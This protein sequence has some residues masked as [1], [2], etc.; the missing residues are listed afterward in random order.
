VESRR[1]WL[2][3]ASDTR[4]MVA[5]L[6]GGVTA[7]V[8]VFVIL[9]SNASFTESSHSEGNKVS[10]GTVGLTLSKSDPI[11]DAADLVPGQ[12]RSGDIQVTNTGNRA[13]LSVTPTGVPGT[14]ALAHA[15]KLKITPTGQPGNVV[16]N[17]PLAPASRIDLGTQSPGQTSAWTFEL[18]L[19]ISAAGLRGAALNAGFEW[20][21]RAP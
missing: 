16:H 5:L 20:E 13:R 11:V 15:L 14:S 12:S 1:T 3:F 7:F 18:T 10:A 2:D 4:V 9:F 21:V 6:L 8:V 19:P 17:A